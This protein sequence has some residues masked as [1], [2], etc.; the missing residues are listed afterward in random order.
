MVQKS[1]SLKGLMIV[2][3]N[4]EIR[5]GQQ[6]QPTSS[7][8][9]IVDGQSLECIDD[10]Q[11][12]R[13]RGFQARAVLIN[14]GQANAATGDAGYQDVIEYANAL[15]TILQIRPEEVLIESADSAA[16]AITT[17]DLVSKSVAIEYEILK[18]LKHRSIR[19]LSVVAFELEVVGYTIALAYCL[20]KGLPFS[21]YGELAFLL[22]QG[23]EM[24]KVI[25]KSIK[26][27]LIFP[28]VELGHKVL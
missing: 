24:T 17:T 4:V 5:E 10:I 20:H 18:V 16:V 12:K 23:D 8:Y 7:D 6:D 2:N 28:F 25:W 9:Q 19:G 15:A 21:A 13:N 14:A 27:K 1:R 11:G 22:I 3:G 26:D